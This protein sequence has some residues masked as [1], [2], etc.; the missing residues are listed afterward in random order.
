MKLHH[1][2]KKRFSRP[3][4]LVVM[5]IVIQMICQVPVRAAGS[6]DLSSLDSIIAVGQDGRLAVSEFA[7]LPKTGASPSLHFFVP[8]VNYSAES[9]PP[10]GK[11]AMQGTV[12]INKVSAAT[13]D[14]ETEYS[15]SAAPGQNTYTVSNDST[16]T[17]VSLQP[18]SPPTA[19]ET[20]ILTYLRDGAMARYNDV[21]ELDLVLITSGEYGAVQSGTVYLSFPQAIDLAEVNVFVHGSPRWEYGPGKDQNT[22]LGIDYY[23]VDAGGVL[24]IRVLMP[25]SYVPSCTNVIQGNA[26]QAVLAQEGSLGNLPLQP[27]P[28]RAWQVPIIVSA[29]WLLF[30]I[31]LYTAYRLTLFPRGTGSVTSPP[32]ALP[33]AL[34]SRL[35]SP[36][37]MDPGVLLSVFLN[38]VRQGILSLAYVENESGQKVFRFSPSGKSSVFAMNHEKALLEWISQD[39]GYDGVTDLELKSASLHRPGQYYRATNDVMI[40]LVNDATDCGLLRDTP[41]VFRW[42]WIFLALAPAIL[43]VVYVFLGRLEPLVLL[44]PAAFT[45]VFRLYTRKTPSEKSMPESAKWRVYADWLAGSPVDGD[46]ES[47]EDGFLYAVALGTS[48]GYA[49]KLEGAQ[50]PQMKESSILAPFMV[51]GRFSARLFNRLL[52]SFK[53]AAFF[54]AALR[55][56]LIRSARKET[57][58]RVKKK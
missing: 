30:V 21:A 52:S 37:G 12:T 20:Y 5:V 6:Y 32:S 56:S 27:D 53:F 48:K 1:I 35:L 18:S 55:S 36:M 19:K 43:A 39:A 47:V 14:N 34:A 50:T 13:G 26:R 40:H 49:K 58:A 28:I 57:Y 25:A 9:K 3:V 23:G 45:L 51:D 11:E 22:L 54:S 15:L 29:I 42:L 31:A 24:E 16:G 2:F 38:L 33:P 7:T 17:T 8:T 4:I 10:T 44:L 41:A 46:L